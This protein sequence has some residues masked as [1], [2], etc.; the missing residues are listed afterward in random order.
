MN[1][2][3]KD[4]PEFILELRKV[5]GSIKGVKGMTEV[6]SFSYTI[7]AENQ[8]SADAINRVGSLLT[9]QAAKNQALDIEVVAVLEDDVKEASEAYKA[10]QAEK[11]G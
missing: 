4:L 1:I 5:L 10:Y 6:V 3:E 11:N 9:E 2:N 8:E 7:V